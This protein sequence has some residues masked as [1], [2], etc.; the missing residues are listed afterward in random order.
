MKHSNR[1]F[2]TSKLIG[3]RSIEGYI[4]TY[5][6]VEDLTDEELKQHFS[7]AMAEEDYEYA[8]TVQ[9]EAQRRGFTILMKTTN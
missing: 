6:I 2:R 5:F 3:T 4:V 9:I 8:Q 1:K 7:R